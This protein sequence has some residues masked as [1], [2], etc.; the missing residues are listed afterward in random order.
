VVV[1][2][3]DATA[4]RA[5][6]E[7]KWCRENKMQ[8]VLSD[9][10]KLSLAASFDRIEAC[11]L[12]V[13]APAHAWPENRWACAAL[14]ADGEWSTRDLLAR[15]SDEWG[16]LL[17]GNQTARPIRLPETIA[18]TLL[19]SVPIHLSDG[20][21]WQLRGVRVEDRAAGW[22]ELKDGWPRSAAEEAR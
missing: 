13:G 12:I 20:D 21:V 8:E 7:L 3:P 17:T 1:R 16:Y 11:Y 6:A 22:V 19:A 5:F 18:T 14:L 10:L 9:L 4:Q 2:D 15:Y